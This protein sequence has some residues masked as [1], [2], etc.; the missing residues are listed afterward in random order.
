[1]IQIFISHS[2]LDE[3][4]AYKLVTFLLAALELKE[5]NILCPSNPDQGLSY[6]S[7]TITDQLKEQLR[8]SEALIILITADSLNSAWIPFEAGSFWTTDKPIIP[9]LGPGLTENDLSGPLKSLLIIPIDAK[10][11]EDRLNNATTQIAKELNLQPKW[12][13]RRNSTL[14][15]FANFL[16]AWQ[17]KR[18]KIDLLQQQEIDE[19]KAQIQDLEQSYNQ[20]FE[21]KK[22]LDQERVQLAQQLEQKELSYKQQLK[23]IEATYQEE[24]KELE[25]DYQNQKQQWEE[26]L[27]S[28]IFIPILKSRDNSKPPLLVH[29]PDLDS[30]LVKLV[31]AD[32][33]FFPELKFIEL[34]NALPGA[35]SPAIDQPLVFQNHFITPLIPLKPLLLEYLTPEDL[36]SKIKFQRFKTGVRLI[37]DLSLSGIQQDQSVEE[38][39]LYKDYELKEK[40]SL[41]D[42]LPV[43]QVWPNFQKRDWREYYI[44]YYDGE[45][46]EQT[47]KI[48][49]PQAKKAHTFTQGFGTF[50]IYNS[51]KF[52][53]YFLCTDFDNNEIGLIFFQS[54]MEIRDNKHWQIGVDFGA[55]FTNIYVNANKQEIPQLL[56]LKNLQLQI[57][58]SDN[59]TRIPTLFEY[60][61]PEYFNPRDDPKSLPLSSVLTT[62]KKDLTNTRMLPIL[63]YRIYTP[64]NHTLIQQKDWIKTNLKWSLSNRLNNKMFLK[65][66]ALH[67]SAL[68][69]YEGV[70]E[71][72]WTVSYP[73][74]FSRVDISDYS[75]VWLNVIKELANSTGIKQN[76]PELGSENFRTDSLAIAQYFADIENKDLLSTTCIEIGGRTYNISIWEENSLVHQCS[77]QLAGQDIFSQFIKFNP[78]F[79]EEKFG[80][81]P[82]EWQDLGPGVFSAK[83]DVWL[84]YESQQWLASN[85]ALQ[86]RDPEFQGLI[87]LMTIG[88]AGVY[89]YVGILLKVL[90]LEEKYKQDRI[91]PVYIGGNASRFLNWLD[92]RGKFDENSEINELFSRMLSKASGFEDT[93]EITSLSCNP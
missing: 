32:D 15:E 5:E 45:L 36:L 44:F 60:F 35:L 81:Y 6:S 34:E 92:D 42:Q 71:I 75:D 30:N 89:Y 90:Y 17:S 61:I 77:V 21:E 9:I 68:A 1:M 66:L 22:K 69:A 79:A 55:S 85:R 49:Y 54:P 8:N 62:R 78:K 70:N 29:D 7:S 58:D 14:R 50:Q 39:H 67:I 18:P 43:L 63:D 37:L 38:Y 31:K 88:I 65:H 3:A 93:E 24:K 12:T 87:R 48:K 2:H 76:P 27:Q 40:N 82:K 25:R 57:T 91:T 11:S 33:L 23:E 56:D 80:L 26:S 4:I 19:L 52:P 28:Q 13:K 74:A 53:E 83:L 51:E 20:Q 46:A 59:T 41:G 10:D 72:Q 86:R 64:Q 73:S 84:R 47:F 16:R